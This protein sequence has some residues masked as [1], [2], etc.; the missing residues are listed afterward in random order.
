MKVEILTLFLLI[1]TAQSTIGQ[2]SDDNEGNLILMCMFFGAPSGSAR[3][4]P[5]LSQTC[6]SDHVHTFYGPQNFHPDTTYED[7]RDTNPKYST[8]P[9]EENQS[10]YWHPTIY[11]I[12]ND[13][14]DSTTEIYTRVDNLVTSPYYRWDKSALPKT[15]AFPPG[16]QMI[17]YSTRDNL[18]VECC[19]F[20]P[21]GD[22]ICSQKDGGME[23]PTENCDH[24][25]IALG[26]LHSS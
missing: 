17:A 12:S 8:S 19:N 10:L 21:D 22:E 25:G 4:D 16:F 18:F 3:T 7:L 1:A 2:S 15:E 24:A 20:T 26:K 23:F 14:N 6:A 9:F 13:E 5:I 11:K